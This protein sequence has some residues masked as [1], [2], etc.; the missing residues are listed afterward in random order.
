YENVV[1][2]ENIETEST[3]T[4]IITAIT[5]NSDHNRTVI[6]TQNNKV[7]TISSEL[8]N[9]PIRNSLQKA[10]NLAKNIEQAITPQETL[11]KAIYMIMAEANHLYEDTELAQP[12]EASVDIQKASWKAYN[13]ALQH[14]EYKILEDHWKNSMSS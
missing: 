1:R 7:E 2:Q 6:I 12:E 14:K 13:N 11:K 3:A 10:N 8:I 9:L 5:S 4:S